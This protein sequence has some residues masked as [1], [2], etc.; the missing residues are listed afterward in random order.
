[1]GAGSAVKFVWTIGFSARQNVATARMNL[2]V[3]EGML[4]IGSTIPLADRVDGAPPRDHT[5]TSWK[6]HEALACIGFPVEKTRLVKPHRKLSGPGH[7]ADRV[8]DSGV[9]SRIDDLHLAG[10]RLGKAKGSGRPAHTS[11]E[12]V[13]PEG[14]GGN[15]RRARGEHL[16]F[17]DADPVEPTAFALDFEPADPTA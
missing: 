8:D 4:I 10:F 15:A 1:M 5:R 12:D 14:L 6:H 3:A 7:A 13:G 9:S 2:G 11:R 16:E 17:D